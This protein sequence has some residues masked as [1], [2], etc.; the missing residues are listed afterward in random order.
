[1]APSFAVGASG[2]GGSCRGG[3]G[4]RY[5]EGGAG[6]GG[7]GDGNFA[8]SGGSKVRGGGGGRGTHGMHTRS[9]MTIDA[10][11]LT[12]WGGGAGG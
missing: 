2:I 6:G 12:I 9:R 10:G 8:L 5:E 7:S 11:I 4:A 3:V 1:M